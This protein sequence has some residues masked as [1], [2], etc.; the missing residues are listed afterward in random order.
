MGI[1]IGKGFILQRVPGWG[2]SAWEKALFTILVTAILGTLVMLAYVVAV[3]RAEEFTEFYILGLEG[4]AADYPERLAVGEEGKVIVGIVNHEGEEV[5]Y[6]L[7]VR[8][9]GEKK[10][11]LEPIVLNNEQKWEEIVDFTVEKAGDK[12]KVE[13][14]LYKL[15]QI[16]VYHSLYLRIDVK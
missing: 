7:E 9:D 8:V 12:Q 13:F 5:N 16:E 10:R 3:P 6:R 4:K 2:A 15:G 11:N 14:L 1:K